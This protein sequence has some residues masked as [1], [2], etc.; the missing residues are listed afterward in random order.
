MLSVIII[1]VGHFISLVTFSMED[2]V[3]IVLL[4]VLLVVDCMA[5]G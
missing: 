5:Y 4:S 1:T 2:F 3:D